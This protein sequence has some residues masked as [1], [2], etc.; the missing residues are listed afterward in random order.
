[1][2][3]VEFY[4]DNALGNICGALVCR[5]EKVILVGADEEK[6]RKSV[7]LYT[8]VLR[9]NSITTCLEYRLIELSNLGSVVDSL[10]QIVDLRDGSCT[11]DLT[12]GD[13]LYL[14]AVGMLKERYGQRVQCHRFNLSHNRVLDCDNDGKT[15]GVSNFDVSVEDVI[16]INGGVLVED[17]MKLFY[18]YP[19]RFDSEFISDV[20]G[21]WSICRSDPKLWNMQITTLG[22]I[23]DMIT[24][25]SSL[26]VSFNQYGADLLLKK[27]RIKYTL[28]PSILERL[29]TFGL[30]TSLCIGSNVSFR[31]KNEQVKKSLTTAGQVLELY[32]A[33]CLL[34]IKDKSGHP[35][36]HDVKVGAVINW[37]GEHNIEPPIIN[38]ID[39]IAMHGVIPVFIS[40]KNGAFDTNEL[41]KLNTV[42]DRFGDDQARKVLVTSSISNMGARADQ[43]IARM[44]EMNIK[45]IDMLS[46]TERSELVNALSSLVPDD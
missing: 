16:T 30:I 28:V 18:T 15:P 13:E 1:M 31:F 27:N 20:Y 3:I 25:P 43:L 21:M 36:Y 44:E 9:D 34:E 7:E 5:P 40:C 10:S 29:E 8:E 42:A 45:C 2:I 39:V 37:D 26:A 24:M 4:D 33:S 38:E 32:V 6:L 22:A 11:F 35:L 46:Y 12:G 17:P 41:Y 14:V 19:W 23:S